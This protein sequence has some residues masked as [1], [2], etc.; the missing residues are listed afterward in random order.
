ML[1]LSQ[2]W[3]S[4]IAAF[5]LTFSVINA[6]PVPGQTSSVLS[7]VSAYNG[8]TTITASTQVV[9]YAA[10]TIST[11]G[12][13]TCT[14]AG[15][16][17]IGTSTTVVSKPTNIPWTAQE[18]IYEYC[19]FSVFALFSCATCPRLITVEKCYLG[20]CEISVELRTPS[21]GTTSTSTSNASSTN[22][23]IGIG[24]LEP[25][26]TT[27]KALSAYAT[28]YTSTIPA[29]LLAAGTVIVGSPVPYVTLTTYLD[30]GSQAYTSTIGGTILDAISITTITYTTTVSAYDS[31]YTSTISAENST[32]GTVIVA[33]PAPFV[34]STI[35][36]D[37]GESAYTSTIG[38]DVNFGVPVG[39]VTTT[40]FLPTDGIAFTS[41][42]PAAGPSS[43][44]VLVGYVQ[45]D[46]TTTI[47]GSAAATS[48]IA[49]SGTIPG[50]IIITVPTPDVNCNNIGVQF[51]AFAET[52]QI[53]NSAGTYANF[54]PVIYKTQTAEITGNTTA[55]S[56]SVTTYTNT[57]VS[58]YG[59]TQKLNDFYLVIDNR[60]Y[61]FAQMTGTYTFST[62]SAD[63][64]F[65]LWVGANAYS[66]WTRANAD[67]IATLT[68][69]S[70]KF[71]IDLVEG[72]YYPI[73]F[74]WANGDGPGLFA[75]SV[76]APD[77][78]TILDGNTV[79]SPY[80]VQF[81]CDGTSAPEYPAWGA[82][83]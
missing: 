40:T 69:P 41:T 16:Y 49:P 66:G 53:I 11:S 76:T 58:V 4:C 51:A 48:T 38:G 60:G 24:Y 2:N 35:Y 23:I 3:R 56:Y 44:T 55:V 50:T 42:V 27:T 81:S 75:F 12:T 18:V 29:K 5:A 39:T 28:G 6:S 54:D 26:V 80:V 10:T 37:N 43:G 25:T 52:P 65:F 59:S 71:T 70:Q 82:E 34:T 46:V 63:D 22:F 45:S 77:G 61:L 57:A 8:A 36:L 64:I 67:L 47:T 79:A 31:A 20:Y 74:L 14:K 17:S 13:L 1:S 9:T 78:T 19:P 62:T 68:Y 83:N 21:K 33:T 15:T 30:D 73:R 7:V 32:P 72:E